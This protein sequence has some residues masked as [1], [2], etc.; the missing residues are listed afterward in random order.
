MALLDRSLFWTAVCIVEE[1]KKTLSLL[2]LSA[3]ILAV[4]GSALAV[5][6]KQWQYSKGK[7]LIFENS[8]QQTFHAK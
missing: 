6:T 3:Y 2:Q 1:T 7:K 4:S 8:E 5:T